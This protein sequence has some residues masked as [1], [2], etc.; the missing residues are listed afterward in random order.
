[1][2]RVLLYAVL[3]YILYRMVKNLLSKPKKKKDTHIGGNS[4]GNE[5]RPYD[6]SNVED[7]DY[8]EL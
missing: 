2:L 7:I 6:K 8:E 5:P 4:A 1:M 3:F